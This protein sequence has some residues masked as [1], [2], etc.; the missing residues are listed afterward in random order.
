MPIQSTTDCGSETTLMYGL[1]TAL[2]FEVLISVI[3][4][5]ANDVF[6]ILGNLFLLLWTS[7]DQLILS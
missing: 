4:F 6:A 1:A 7:W 3:S 5:L 2:R